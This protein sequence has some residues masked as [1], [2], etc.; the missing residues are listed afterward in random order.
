MASV[1]EAIT[2]LNPDL[3]W[4]L[5][6][7]PTNAYEFNT[8]FAVVVDE[9]PNG[10][11][12]LSYEDD[13]WQGVTWNKVEVKLAELNAAEPLKLL[14]EERNR[15]LAETDWWASSDLTMSAE[16][17]AYRQALRDI[18]DTYQSLDTVVWPTKPE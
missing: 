18:T 5:H 11:A 17:T 13:D 9:E 15:R 10:T 8:M 6:G 12:I 1:A 7:E 4:V 3:E 16:R 14:R 2:A